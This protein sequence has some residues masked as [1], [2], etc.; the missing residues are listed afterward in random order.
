LLIKDAVKVAAPEGLP[1]PGALKNDNEAP[2]I[3]EDVIVAAEVEATEAA[4]EVAV[5]APAAEAPVETPVAE[6]A[7]APEAGEAEKEG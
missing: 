2:V 7:A 1:F 6:E 5:E 4:V 3:V